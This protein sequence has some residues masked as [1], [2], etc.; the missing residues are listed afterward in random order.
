MATSTRRILENTLF[1]RILI[2]CLLRETVWLVMPNNY[3]D[4]LIDEYIQRK[5]E[6][7]AY[8]ERA[9]ARSLGLSAGFLKLL[10]QGKKNLSFSRA[11]VLGNKLDWSESKKSLFLNKVRASS[12][13]KIKSQIRG[14]IILKEED[15]FEISDWYHFAIIEFVKSWSYKVTLTDICKGLKISKTEANYAIKNLKKIGLIVE[16][17]KM[18]ILIPE[19]YEIPSISSSGIR[20]YHKQTLGL[21]IE[22][23]E[24]QSFDKR[25]Y[26]ALTLSFDSARTE[27]AK[28]YFEKFVSKFDKKFSSNGTKAVYQLN[29]CFY[30]L[31]STE[32]L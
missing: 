20:K 11:K 25:D 24:N 3:V 27:E 29:T 4:L 17:K 32:G 5:N 21:A 7:R 18:G 13:V 8:S 31:D 12:S 9:F 16:T 22:A 14:K 6:Y 28:K 26:R 19:Y 2:Q 23:I 10:F 1:S 30:R 15:F